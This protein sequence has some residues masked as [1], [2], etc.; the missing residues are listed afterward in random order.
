MHIEPTSI[1][2]V[3][4]VEMERHADDRGFFARTWCRRELEAHG[5]DVDV[6]QCS[7]SHNVEVGTIR[8]L[9]RQAEPHEEAKYV[10]VTRGAIFDVAVDVRPGSATYKQWLGVELSAENGRMLYVPKGCL[11]GFQTLAPDSEVY[12]Q[13]TAYYH[14]EAKSGARY[15][16]PAFGV[17]WPL[18]PRAL[19]PADLA[20]GPFEA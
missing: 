2:G 12:Y 14:P 20:F 9:H 4:V 6:V 13:I 10:R 5:L 8:G 3:H 11:H 1:P 15:D 17:A 16:D 18:P 7:L 19:S